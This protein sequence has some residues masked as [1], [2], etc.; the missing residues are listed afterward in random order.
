MSSSE[1]RP[2]WKQPL[3]PVAAAMPADIVHRLKVVAGKHNV[4]LA[5]VVRRAV[6]VGLPLVEKERDG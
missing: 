3:V 1:Q 6:S 5:A 4:T 2:E